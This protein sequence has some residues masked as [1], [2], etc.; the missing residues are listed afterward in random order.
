MCLPILAPTQPKT[1]SI[2]ITPK[3]SNLD[4]ATKKARAN[5][6]ARA[7]ANQGRQSTLLTGSLGLQKSAGIKKK[8]LL[9]E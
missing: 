5:D 9:G 8:N 4:D 7:R 6:L 2:A 3:T 1:S